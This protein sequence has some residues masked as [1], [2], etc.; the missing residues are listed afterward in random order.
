MGGQQAMVWSHLLRSDLRVRSDSWSESWEVLPV[1]RVMPRRRHVSPLPHVSPTP[2]EVSPPPRG[3]IPEVRGLR[4]ALLLGSTALAA[5][6]L[7][8][9]TDAIFGSVA[10][11]HLPHTRPPPQRAASGGTDGNNQGVGGVG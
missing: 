5:V 10:A 4:R 1:T 8:V 9:A 6:I 2:V 11:G 3:K 7:T